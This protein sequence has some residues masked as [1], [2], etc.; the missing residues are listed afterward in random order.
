MATLI[1]SGDAVAINQVDVLIVFGT[2]E[3]TDVFRMTI[4]GKDLDV[5]AGS[6]DADTVAATIAAAWNA[7]TIPEFAE[8]TALEMGENGRITLTAKTAGVPFTVT[9]DSFED[10]YSGA[11]DDQDFTQT[12]S[13]ANDGPNVW[14]AANFKTAGV[15]GT[16]PEGGDTVIFRDSAVDMKYNLNQSG[17]GA[18]L[19]LQIEASYTGEV[20]LPAVNDSGSTEYDEYRDRELNLDF[21]TLEIGKGEGSGSPKLRLKAT[22]AVTTLLVFSTGSSSDD[23]RTVELEA[24]GKA[25]T[26]ASILSGSVEMRDGGSA[27]AITTLN[28]EGDADVALEGTGFDGNI[29]TTNVNGT[30]TLA[31]PS[32]LAAS[33][34]TINVRGGVVE[35]QV[36]NAHTT[37]N[38][39][40][41]AFNFAPAGPLT[42][43]NLLI[44]PTGVFNTTDA[45]ATVTIGNTTCYGDN[46][47]AAT[48]LDPNAKVDF[49][50]DIDIGF[51]KQADFNFDFGPGRD[52]GVSGP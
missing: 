40:S 36:D 33:F 51:G 9:V 24:N 22:D 14:S 25:I 49:S 7:S 27:T 21:V 15:R 42:I 35:S 16:L 26:T 17:A 8:V 43:T 32:G 44:G 52:V 4:N 48:I 10:I 19:V 20:G 45:T 11:Y 38:I 13:T 30:S 47:G 6:T 50:S 39:F 1:F 3:A 2:I 18:D 12:T 23:Q 31:M 41:G 34:T 46:S 29:T 5:L 37:V 28:T